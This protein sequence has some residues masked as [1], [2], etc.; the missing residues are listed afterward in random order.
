MR[1]SG[2]FCWS[3]TLAKIEMI[4]EYDVPILFIIFKRDYTA[5]KVFER[6]KEIKPKSYMLLLMVREIS[7]RRIYV[8]KHVI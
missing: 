4:M 7:K 8:T 5:I 2:C 3:I 1:L 6:I